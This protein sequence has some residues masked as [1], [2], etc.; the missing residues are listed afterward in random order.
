[1]ECNNRISI[2]LDVRQQLVRNPTIERAGVLGPLWSSH[3]V[4]R[5][6][7]PTPPANNRFVDNPR[8]QERHLSTYRR[9]QPLHKFS[10]VHT[11]T[12]TRSASSRSTVTKELGDPMIP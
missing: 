2:E 7:K 4:W 12:E 3:A 1:M 5:V 10:I 11:P 6:L 8:R 9:G